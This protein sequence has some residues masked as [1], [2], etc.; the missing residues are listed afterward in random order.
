[1]HLFNADRV[2]P[3]KGEAN[4]QAHGVSFAEAATVVAD[5]YALIREDPDAIGEQR[6]VTLGMSA[7]GTAGGRFR[8]SGTRP[9][10]PDLGLEGQ[11]TA[12]EAI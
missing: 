11:Q 4:L 8:S 12:E 9:L 3:R 7:T 6:F 1:M 10:S 5:D 2:D